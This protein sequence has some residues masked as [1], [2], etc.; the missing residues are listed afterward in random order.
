MERARETAYERDWGLTS[1]SLEFGIY[2][3][4]FGI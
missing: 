3:L 4:G 2:G 1:F